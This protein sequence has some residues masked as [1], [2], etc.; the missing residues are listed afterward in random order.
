MARRLAAL[1]AG[2]AL[3]L[4]AAVQCGGVDPS[5]HPFKRCPHGYARM[6]RP[7]EGSLHKPYVCEKF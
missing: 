6:Y 1:A 7:A 5:S 2:T 4:S 3:V